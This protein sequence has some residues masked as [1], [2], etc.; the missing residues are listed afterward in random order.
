MDIKWT[1]ELSIGVEGIDLQHKEIIALISELARSV[2]KND[3][4]DV[5]L[6]AIDFLEQYVKKHFAMEERLMESLNYPKDK[7]REQEEQH[8]SFWDCYTGIRIQFE[9]N[10]PTVELTKLIKNVLVDW[11]INH[12]CSVDK[13]I[14]VFMNTSK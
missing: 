2:E 5:T 10:G 14:G 8:S 6:R 13:S 4:L 9:D 1:E 11:F 7:Y 12:I 3:S